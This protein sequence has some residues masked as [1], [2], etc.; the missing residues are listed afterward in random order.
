MR[1]SSPH[2]KAQIGSVSSCDSAERGTASSP[3]GLIVHFLLPG[4][5]RAKNG[6][7][8]MDASKPVIMLW[9]FRVLIFSSFGALWIRFDAFVFNLCI[10]AM[11][12]RVAN[13]R[14]AR[15][16]KTK[17]GREVFPIRQSPF[18]SIRSLSFFHSYL[19][20]LS[21]ISSVHALSKLHLS[22]NLFS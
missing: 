14:T 12:D 13:H 6:M 4:I 18:P 8:S 22:S 9:I 19:S 5:N 3:T 16:A 20:I 21:W 15:N 17:H 1:S 11:N 2:V 10:I 7:C